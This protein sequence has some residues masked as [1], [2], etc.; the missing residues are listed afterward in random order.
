[1]RRS[2]SSLRISNYVAWMTHLGKPGL[3]RLA[4]KN[5]MRADLPFVLP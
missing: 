1:M 5:E 4:R 3:F 2:R